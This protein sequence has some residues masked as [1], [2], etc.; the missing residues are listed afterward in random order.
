MDKSSS[1]YGNFLS[2]IM[3]F[4]NLLKYNEKTK[5]YNFD[6]YRWMQDKLINFILVEGKKQSKISQ[7]FSSSLFL[8]YDKI[9]NLK[10]DIISLINTFG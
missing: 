2:W 5:A 1:K 8:R 6:I 10:S 7:Q 3:N 4:L 9:K